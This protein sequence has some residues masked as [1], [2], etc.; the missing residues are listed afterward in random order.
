MKITK[1]IS[2]LVE[3]GAER[4]IVELLLE[5]DMLSSD[6]DHVESLKSSD[7]VDADGYPGFNYKKWSSETLIEVS[8]HSE[9]TIIIVG[10][11]LYKNKVSNVKFIE[12]SDAISKVILGSDYKKRIIKVSISPEP[13]VLIAHSRGLTTKWEKYKTKKKGNIFDFLNEETGLGRGRIP[14]DLYKTEFKDKDHFRKSISKLKKE[15]SSTVIGL[16][17]IIK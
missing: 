2:F 3:G 1:I 17:D 7:I 13:E 4:A 8:R 5:F 11:Q 6:F 9:V 14:Y 15:K 16:S 12:D 10:D